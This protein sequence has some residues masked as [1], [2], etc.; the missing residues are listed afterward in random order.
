MPPPRGGFK[1]W[2]AHPFSG[3]ARAFTGPGL[4]LEVCATTERRR[5]GA[6]SPHGDQGTRP[7]PCPACTPRKERCG[8]HA[9]AS[10]SLTKILQTVISLTTTNAASP[11]G[12]PEA[13]VLVPGLRTENTGAR[14]VWKPRTVD[15]VSGG[16]GINGP[17]PR[18]Q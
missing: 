17:G 12:H 10:Y 2:C 8:R 4:A 16:P 9:L 11:H 14:G 13:A 3:P 6:R 1:S 15:L 5:L 7:A 18:S